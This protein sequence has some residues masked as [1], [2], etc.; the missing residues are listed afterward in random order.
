MGAAVLAGELLLYRAWVVASGPTRLITCDEPATFFGRPGTQG[1]SVGG[2]RRRL[3]RRTV[4]YGGRI[5]TG[6]PVAASTSSR[7]PSGLAS[8]NT[9]GSEQPPSPSLILNR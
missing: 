4:V 9:I 1:A 6:V 3:S 5:T 2:R 7:S 8:V